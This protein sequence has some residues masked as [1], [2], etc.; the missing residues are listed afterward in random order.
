MNQCE[1]CE[2]TEF[3]GTVR[4]IN[5]YR[6]FEFEPETRETYDVL[7]RECAEENNTLTAETMT[8]E[9]LIAAIISDSIGYAGP[10]HAARHVADYRA[11]QEAVE[12]EGRRYGCW[13]E[14]G[15]AVFKNDLDALIARAVRHWGFQS[16]EA[17]QK[18]LERVAR[19]KEIE[20]EDRIASLGL[21]MMA[22]VGGI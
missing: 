9:E 8:D 7:C 2:M 19:W 22:P 5:T 13:C 1:I 3:G 17:R 18:K 12:D 16:D 21:S 10:H 11:G 4:P 6:E 14:R 15:S 20:D